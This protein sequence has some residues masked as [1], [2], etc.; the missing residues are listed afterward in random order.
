MPA[1]AHSHVIAPYITRWS[2]EELPPSRLVEHPGR[3]IAYVDEV[4]TDR[5][6]KGVLWYRAGFRPRQGRPEFSAVHPLRQ[7][8]A[9]RRLLCQV[10]AQPADQTEDGVLWLLQDHRTDWPGWPENM[11]VT[12]PPVCVPCVTTATR[13]CP[14]LRQGAA[15]IRVRHCPV[16]GVHAILYRHSPRGPVPIGGELVRYDDPVLRWACATNL[17]RELHDCTVIDRD[18]LCLR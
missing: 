2:A 7:R 12:E 14:A 3:G 9:M 5:D 6:D 11:A 15:L 17:I 16:I 4:V 18:D 13:L 8:R 1:A 10:C